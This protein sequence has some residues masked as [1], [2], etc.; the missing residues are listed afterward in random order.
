ML[1]ALLIAIFLPVAGLFAVAFLG[2]RLGMATRWLA[3]PFPVISF[4]LI[5]WVAATMPSGQQTYLGPLP[6][7]PSL[8]INLVFL[9]DGLSTFFGMVVS[10]M[11]VLIFFY[12]SQY[13]DSHY[14]F[15]SRFYAYL[16]LF[17]VA[18][19]GTVFSGNL[20]MLFVWWELTGVASFFLIGFLHSKEESRAGARM[21]FLSTV[22]MGLLFLVG[23][24]LTG[25]LSG[26]FDF[27][28]ILNQPIDTTNPLWLAAMIL[29]F[30]GAIGKSAQFPFHYW[31]PNAMAA[32]TPVSAYLHSATMVKL[33]VFLTAR[34]FPVYNDLDLWMPLVTVIGFFTFL[35]GSWLAL[36]S[37]KLKA[38]LAFSTVA[39]LGML[40]GFYGMSPTTGA[41]WDQLHI[42]NHVFYKGCLFMVVGIIDHATHLK[43][44]RQLGGLRKRL[45]LLALIAGIGCASMASLMLTTGF[46]SKEYVLKD[47]LYFGQKEGGLL[48]WFPLIML[49]LGSVFKVAF[50]AR[51]F[52]A[53]FTGP[54]TE[55]VK[56]HF[57]HPGWLIHLPPL[58]LAGGTLV[59][60]IA[61]WL[62]HGYLKHATVP[63]INAIIGEADKL[64]LWPDGGFA[65]PAFQVSL[66]ILAVGIGVYVLSEKIKWS[67]T[68]IPKWAQ[69]DGGFEWL[70]ARVPAI[71]SWTNRALRGDNPIDYIPVI[72]G[73]MVAVVG[74]FMV[75][76]GLPAMVGASINAGGDVEEGVHLLESALIIL[77]AWGVV[78]ARQ[79]TTQLIFLSTLGF[80][81]TFYF[82]L[83]RAPDLAMTQ[84]LVEAGT[85]ILVLLLLARF[86]KSAQAGEI[87]GSFKGFRR[88]L[89][90]FIATGTGLMVFAFTYL[91]ATHKHPDPIGMYFIENTEKKA[92]GTN[93]VNTILVDFRGTD[94]LLEVGVLLIA[95]L[96][97]LGLLMRRKRTPEEMAAGASGPA[98]LGIDPKPATVRQKEGG[99]S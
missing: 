12:A 7:I 54:E 55:E 78:I 28:T 93:A 39:Q 95:G 79:W 92:Y 62:L 31:L 45:P 42:L 58:L 26:S 19:L 61:P 67:R 36:R 85:L 74:G 84:I 51:L 30:C 72:A 89:N 60:G 33:G 90:M 59:F 20:M 88:Y 11:G 94:T 68:G 1:T 99:L 17:M 3:L 8:G 34:M 56:K 14:K 71:G 83:F 76:N 38:I 87:T 9:V 47:M 44:I 69:F 80:L 35:T 86:P 52:F 40:I 48:G 41:L 65:N 98:G 64:K 81:V 24:V 16:L 37:N 77:A 57:H 53:I 2:P 13:L 15:H 21:A 4:A 18:M 50:S 66:A 91:I 22:G 97:A 63:G 32:P 6:W 29:V 75:V 73:V 25:Q 70:V 27:Q 82:I 96:G 46:I 23:V 49:A 10:G 43:D 5:A